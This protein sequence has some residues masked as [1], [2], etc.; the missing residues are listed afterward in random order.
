MNKKDILIGA[1]AGIVILVAGLAVG[2]SINK[3]SNNALG[4][5]ASKWTNF[6]GSGITTKV[7]YAITATDDSTS[8]L[9]TG[10]AL[11][12]A[13]GVVQ[14]GVD[15]TSPA[16]QALAVD[17]ISTSTTLS[18]NFSCQYSILDETT[19]TGPITL[20]LPS[21]TSTENTCLPAVGQY[22]ISRIYVAPGNSYAITIA[23]STGDSV[24]YNP[25][26]TMGLVLATSSAGA[27]YTLESWDL[28][29]ANTTSAQML[30]TIGYSGTAH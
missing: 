9:I 3:G 30:Y 26:S 2:L 25:S 29:S 6:A 27:F 20:T 13:G 15:F 28:V 24:F 14:Y 11:P 7:G 5:I 22:N 1:I 18:G 19:S 10:T 4:L 23:T 16:G 12:P 8:T 21:A 17:P